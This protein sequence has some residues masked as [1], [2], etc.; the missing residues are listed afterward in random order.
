M[1]CCSVSTPRER[2]TRPSAGA[3]SRKSKTCS[4]GTST[5]PTTGRVGRPVALLLT[6]FDRVLAGS[7]IPRRDSAFEAG[8]PVELVE[9]LVDERYGMTRHALA[10]ARARGCGL[11]RQLIRHGGRWQSPAGRD[12]AAGA[13]GPARL[14]GR[15]ARGRRPRRYG[16]AL[17]A[18]AGDCPG[19]DDAWR[20]TRSGYPRLE[21]VV[22]VPRPVQEA[23]A[24]ARWRRI[25]ALRPP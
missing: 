9:R 8:V 12:P 14:G 5:G 13:R 21:P 23:G 4:K 3:A 18:G 2:P 10:A 6:K 19:S 20:P 1:P 17:E 16:A 24:R 22:R 11:R 7:A 25:S 15:A